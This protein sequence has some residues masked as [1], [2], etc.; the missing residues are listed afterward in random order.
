MRSVVLAVSVT[1]VALVSAPAS[2][3]FLD[4]LQSYWN[5]DGGAADYMDKVGSLHMAEKGGSD[6]ATI[7]N[8]ETGALIGRSVHATDSG[9]WLRSVNPM[10]TLN[11]TKELTISYWLKMDNV[12]S[13]KRHY[14]H[15]VSNDPDNSVG[16]FNNFSTYNRMDFNGTNFWYAFFLA[17][18]QG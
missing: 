2:A 7:E 4:G 17:P 16:S 5:F 11:I 13:H 8:K 10:G 3:N 14:S 18:A 9:H 12:S 6:L 1:V 15:R